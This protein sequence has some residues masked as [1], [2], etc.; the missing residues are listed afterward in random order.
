MSGQLPADVA[1]SR[2]D[3]LPVA[4]AEQARQKEHAPDEYP[5]KIQKA[6]P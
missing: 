3:E 4:K 1:P 2:S 5:Q 6:R